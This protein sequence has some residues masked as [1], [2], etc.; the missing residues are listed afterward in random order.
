M[1]YLDTAFIA[2][3]YLNEPGAEKVRAAA[4]N[5]S[6]LAS[7]RL[8]RIEFWSVLNRHLRE[9]RITAGQA[10]AIRRKVLED[11]TKR[12][13]TWFPVTDRLLDAA[14]ERLERLPR[15]LSVSAA[16]AIHLTCAQMQGFSEIHTSDA[17]MLRCAPHFGLQGIDLTSTAS[18]SAT[19]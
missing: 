18:P 4:R 3:C 1:I 12:I 17:Q 19:C 10:A 15:A 8:G 14:C 5:A 13:W 7:A 11:E 16:D 6:G 2:K 9:G